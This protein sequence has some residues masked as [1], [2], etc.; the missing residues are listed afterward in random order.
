MQCH[1]NCTGLGVSQCRAIIEGRVFVSQPGLHHLKP[2]CLERSSNLHRK[3][4]NDFAF[5]YPAGSARPRVRATVR[6][7]ENYD[8]QSWPRDR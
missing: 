5:A 7:I 3:L 6:G 4:Q 8:I 2:L 1:E